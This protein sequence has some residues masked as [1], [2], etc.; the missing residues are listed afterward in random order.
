MKAPDVVLRNALLGNATI[1]GLVA[2][3][4]RPV[5][6]PASTQL[7]Y[8]A[9]R[10]TGIK[11]EQTLAGPMGVPTVTMEFSVFGSTYESA[12]TVADAVRAVLDGYNGTSENTTVR[13]TSLESEA[14]DLV[15]LAGAEIANTYLITQTYD[16]IYQET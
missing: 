5:M 11:R 8:V 10:R 15:Q 4:V 12:R 2:S 13:Q 1:T 16:V 7:P 14:D 3:R 6:F 9:Y